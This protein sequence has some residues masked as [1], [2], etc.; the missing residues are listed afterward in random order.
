MCGEKPLNCIVRGKVFFR[1][2]ELEKSLRKNATRN[3]SFDTLVCALCRNVV[4]NLERSKGHE[5]ESRNTQTESLNSL[6]ERVR[7]CTIGQSLNFRWSHFDDNAYICMGIGEAR[8]TK[9]VLH[10]HF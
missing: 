9:N 2:G 6:S 3:F 5:G 7:V 4:L 10:T 8:C 1:T